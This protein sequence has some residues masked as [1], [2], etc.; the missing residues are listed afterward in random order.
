VVAQLCISLVRKGEIMLG[1]F[2][3]GIELKSMGFLCFTDVV[4]DFAGKKT[5]TFAESERLG[6]KFP[7]FV[8]RPFPQKYMEM[9]LPALMANTWDGDNVYLERLIGGFFTVQQ[10]QDEWLR[11]LS[12]GTAGHVMDKHWVRHPTPPIGACVTRSP[13]LKTLTSHATEPATWL[14]VGQGMWVG[15]RH[16]GKTS[17]CDAIAEALGDLLATTINPSGLLYNKSVPDDPEKAAGWT[18]SIRFPRWAFVHEVR[19][20]SI[21]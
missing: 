8:P 10:D 6:H 7:S 9:G 1:Q 2:E 4:Y 3:T 5:I 17:L 14:V 15:K 12:R 19:N 20:H 21:I 11:F 18:Q 13:T 16:A